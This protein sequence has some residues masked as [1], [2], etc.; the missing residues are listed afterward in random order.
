MSLAFWGGIQPETP[1]SDVCISYALAYSEKRLS[2]EF[3]V[4]VNRISKRYPNSTSP[5]VLIDHGNYEIEKSPTNVED[6]IWRF[7][8]NIGGVPEGVSPS[9]GEAYA[10]MKA[11]MVACYVPFR[12]FSEED[13][14]DLMRLKVY[15]LS[16]NIIARGNASGKALTYSPWQ[17]AIYWVQHPSPPLL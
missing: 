5:P 6:G 16:M 12:A 4:V 13:F 3:S 2:T 9:M 10:S 8:A 11:K 1:L 7:F 14:L 17:R 15:Q